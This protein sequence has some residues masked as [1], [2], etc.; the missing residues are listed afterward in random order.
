M[1]CFWFLKFMGPTSIKLCV[2]T[3]PAQNSNCKKRG[4]KCPFWV[5]TVSRS[6]RIRLAYTPHVMYSARSLA[7]NLFSSFLV[8]FHQPKNC[9][10]RTR[11]VCKIFG[12]LLTVN[13]QFEQINAIKVKN[14]LAKNKTLR[15]LLLSLSKNYK[16]NQMW[17]THDDRQIETKNVSFG[18]HVAPWRHDGVHKRTIKT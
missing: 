5:G 18:F 6:T 16:S 2:Q 13:E 14:W 4:T 15:G 10:R 3:S 11:R 7:S 17:R 8:H 9:L 1:H 12:Y